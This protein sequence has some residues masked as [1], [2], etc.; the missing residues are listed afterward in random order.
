MLTDIFYRTEILG[1]MLFAAPSLFARINA[2]PWYQDTLQQWVNSVGYAPGDTLLELGCATGQLSQFIA[3]NGATVYAVDKSYRMIA[4]ASA[5]NFAGVTYTHADATNLP[6]ADQRFDAVIAASLLNVVTKPDEVIAEMKRVCHPHG[7]ISI[8]V[9]NKGFTDHD[10]TKLVAQLALTGF[11]RAALIAWHHNATKMSLAE[12]SQLFHR[13]NLFVTA[14][15][16][17]LNGLVITATAT[18]QD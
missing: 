17:Y 9:P 13:A 8:L 7:K 10:A 11:S 1:R 14:H 15:N 16:E 12:V 5:N 2:L 3:Y 6:F 4:K 18:R